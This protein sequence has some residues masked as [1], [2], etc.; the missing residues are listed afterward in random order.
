[1][2]EQYNLSKGSPPPGTGPTPHCQPGKVLGF[3]SSRK[4]QEERGTF[5]MAGKGM[6]SLVI[7]CCRTCFSVAY[8]SATVRVTPEGGDLFEEVPAM[9]VT[10][11]VFPS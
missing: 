10:P 2:K 9:K 5:L 8:F 4:I 1:M 11:A 3:H 7:A 6:S